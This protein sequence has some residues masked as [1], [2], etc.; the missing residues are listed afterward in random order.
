M[1]ERSFGAARR[2]VLLLVAVNCSACMIAKMQQDNQAAVVRID[3]KTDQL[4]REEAQQAQLA[5]AK[6]QLLR[7]LRSRNLSAQE[8]SEQLDK[9]SSLNEATSASSAQVLQQKQQTA[10]KLKDAT[11]Q[12]RA[13]RKPNVGESP[14][15]AAR[16]LAE[17][18]KQIRAR[19]ELMLAN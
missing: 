7:D 2:A 17:T 6:A 1:P 9:L 13:A 15:A 16:R 19:L 10:T 4:K 18:Q 11:E 5:N 12:L 8:L 14:V 3:V